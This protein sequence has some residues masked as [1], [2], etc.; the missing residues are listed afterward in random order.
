MLTYI[1][2]TR[3]RQPMLIINKTNR[4]CI[5]ALS[6]FFIPLTAQEHP[7]EHPSQSQTEHPAEHP[8]EHP[9]EANATPL[10]KE[11]L[12]EAVEDYVKTQ[13]GENEKFVVKDP[14]TGENLEL[15]LIRVHKDRLSGVGDDL[16][17]ACADFKAQNGK[18]YDLDV[19]MEGESV[20]KIAFNK[21]S[22]HKEDSVERYGWAEENGV[23]KKVKLDKEETP[24]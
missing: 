21:F 23:W 10:T 2:L 1:S 4:A 16:Y 14:K 11:A 22:V 15:T 18:V 3:M 9:S 6:F 8:Q 7:K 24:E 5:V 13:S 20:E 17:F 12:A 19:F